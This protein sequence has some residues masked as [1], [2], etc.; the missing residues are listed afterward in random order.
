MAILK[1]IDAA[2]TSGTQVFFQRSGREFI[3][4][5]T[6]SRPELADPRAGNS[7]I[8]IK[9][10]SFSYHF[11]GPVLALR[12]RLFPMGHSMRFKEAGKFL[13]QLL[14]I[15]PVVMMIE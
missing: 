5:R 3:L 9:E 1:K 12:L 15:N 11:G 13:P 10:G 8:E 4:H 6:A 7:P 2:R 14:G